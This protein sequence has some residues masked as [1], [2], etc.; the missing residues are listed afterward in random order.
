MASLSARYILLSVADTAIALLLTFPLTCMYWRGIW[1]LIGHYVLTEKEPLSLWIQTS[2]GLL[3][4]V[5]LML[6]P[7][8]G[9]YLNPS[10]KLTFWIYTRVFM[11]IHTVTYM[12]YWRGFWLLLNYHLPITWQYN[13]ATLVAS[14]LGLVLLG[15][16][17]STM[18]PPFFITID[19]PD[20]FTCANRFGSQVRAE[21]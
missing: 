10:K 1:D 12:F 7:L 15:G 21:W 3:Q 14:L 2:I 4:L 5:G 19:T 20:L 13:V 9:K 6:L 16:L 18:W 11:Y 17:R 8:I